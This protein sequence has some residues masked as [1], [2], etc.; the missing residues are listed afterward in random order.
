MIDCHTHFYDPS[1]PQGVPWPRP[2][3]AVLYRPVYPRDYRAVSR[4]LG[5]TGTVV[6][7]ASA[8]LDDNDWVLNLAA[9]DP[10]I[11]GFVGRLTPGDPSFAGVLSRLSRN[12]L[13]RG[14]RVSG[15]EIGGLTDTARLRDLAAL[16]DH[17]L[18]LDVNGGVASL[19]TVAAVARAVPGLRIIVDHVANVAIDGKAPPADWVT[20]MDLVSGRANVFCKVSGLVEGS[21]R[22]G[23]KAPADLQ[24]YR[25]VLDAVW[26]R[27]GE[28]RL[29]YGSN[30]P[31]SEVFAP[32][33]T[34][35]AIVTQY[36]GGRGDRAVRRYFSE[37]ARAAYK[38]G[39]R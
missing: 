24:F 19:A 4:P 39:K 18:S 34:V 31:V 1:R 16:A 17:D 5:V 7:E 29:L 36:F 27:F 33:G 10:L 26:E 21:G 13:F 22:R 37:N 38:W 30:W 8:W 32:F 15:A 23:G 11:V 6:V 2:S 9:E 28:E 12:P 35:H 20:G 25:P 3:D 14:I